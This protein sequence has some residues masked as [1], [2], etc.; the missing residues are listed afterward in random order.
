MAPDGVCLPGLRMASNTPP[1]EAVS[2][3]PESKVPNQAAG[4]CSRWLNGDFSSARGTTGKQR[5]YTLG[6]EVEKFQKDRRVVRP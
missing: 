1:N 3:V 6:G 4:F 5:G 2:I